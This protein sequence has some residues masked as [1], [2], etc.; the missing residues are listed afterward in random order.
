MR[1]A[2]DRGK[3]TVINQTSTAPQRDAL[4]PGPTAGQ[5]AAWRNSS[6]WPSLTTVRTGR[7]RGG[8]VSWAT[9][10]VAPGGPGPRCVSDV[11][12]A[13]LRKLI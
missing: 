10:V 1:H 3:V 4:T 12:L 13:L 6:R 2:V 7:R 11:C 5:P 9:H 8:T